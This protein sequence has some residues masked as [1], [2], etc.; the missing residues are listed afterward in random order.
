MTH[1]LVSREN[2]QKVLDALNGATDAEALQAIKQSFAYATKAGYFTLETIPERLGV[3]T[4]L[5]TSKPA[6]KKKTE[7]KPTA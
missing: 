2:A 7:E 5:A 6:K 3:I 1:I 4:P